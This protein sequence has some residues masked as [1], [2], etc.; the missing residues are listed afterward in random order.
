MTLS[1]PPIAS[2]MAIKPVR[3]N[4]S[5]AALPFPFV[6]KICKDHI[7]REALQKMN[8]CLFKSH[9]LHLHSHVWQQTFLD[10][11]S[12]FAICSPF[13]LQQL[14]HHQSKIACHHFEHLKPLQKGTCTAG[15]LRFESPTS[16][17][18]HQITQINCP[19]VSSHVFG[20]WLSPTLGQPKFP[21]DF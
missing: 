5:L 19:L 11:C 3:G 14:Q 13:K 10:S 4:I 15:F 17:K 12:G 8:R 16:G 1:T 2:G 7:I 18:F 6:V 21:G 20:A 9:H